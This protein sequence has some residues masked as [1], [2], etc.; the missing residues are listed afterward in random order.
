MKKPKSKLQSKIPPSSQSLEVEGKEVESN[1]STPKIDVLKLLDTVG[2][3]PENAVEAAS[4][5]PR[6]FVR[7]INYR[8]DCLFEKS[9]A[10]L[11][12][13]RIN[14][15]VELDIRNSAKVNDEK[16]TENHIK[17]L[18]VL[19]PKAAKAERSLERAEAFDEY[20][21]LV[22]EVFR[23]QRDSLQVVKGLIS[24]EIRQGRALDQEVESLA[25][26]RKKLKDRFPGDL[27]E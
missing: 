1:T 5:L 18:L 2:F 26:T 15:E 7:A 27:E 23:I 25:V 24:D 14:A 3:A 4:V 21:K 8:L 20:S 19:D 10:K 13:K 12:T 11:Q 16:V 6:L 17:A 9:E 22:V